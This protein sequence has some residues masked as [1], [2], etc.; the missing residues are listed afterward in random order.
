M[1]LWPWIVGGL[2]VLAALLGLAS[3]NRATIF[4]MVAHA[5]LPHVEPNH[6]VTWAQ[7]PEAPPSGERPPNVVFILV[8]D[9]GYNDITFNGG[10]IANGAVP[11][12]NIDSIGHEGVDFVNGYAGNATC[13]PSRAAIMTGRYPTRFGF[14][15]T[16]AP[17]AFEKMVGTAR[18]PG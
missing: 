11:T 8:D 9:L 4:A 18:E 3:A 17:V 5:R 6:P 16:P 15:F 13:A 2:L 10:G 14:E 7:G 1:K 12:P